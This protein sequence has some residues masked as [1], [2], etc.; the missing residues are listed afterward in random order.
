MNKG[1]KVEKGGIWFKVTELGYKDGVK[2]WQCTQFNCE[3]NGRAKVESNSEAFCFSCKNPPK[4]S[5][6][7]AICSKY[8]SLSLSLS[9]LCLSLCLSL[10][11]S[12]CLSVSVSSLS[13][14][15][16]VSVSLSLSLCLSLSLS[17]SVS[18]LSLSLSP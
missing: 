12:L 18:S 17:V 9:L 10:S 6:C 3:K 13:L 7:E 1:K 15:L 5:C 2:I 14:S 11:L 16:C 8:L 4:N